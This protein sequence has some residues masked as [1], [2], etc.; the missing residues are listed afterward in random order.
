MLKKTVFKTACAVPQLG[1]VVMV[2]TATAVATVTT[3][4]L[5]SLFGH[6]IAIVSASYRDC[7]FLPYKSQRP[8]RDRD[9]DRYRDCWFLPY[10]PQR[11]YEILK[12]VILL[13][14]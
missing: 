14:L 12:K 2:A 3:A 7:W 8:Y 5:A 10:K 4:A 11:P 1:F 6:Q 13:S 9:R